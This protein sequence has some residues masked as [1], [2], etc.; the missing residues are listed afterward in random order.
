MT[1]IHTEIT[2]THAQ[3]RFHSNTSSVDG[4]MERGG[5]VFGIRSGASAGSGAGGGC[6]S[7]D[8]GGPDVGAEDDEEADGDGVCSESR[9]DAAFAACLALNASNFALASAMLVLMVEDLAFVLGHVGGALHFHNAILLIE[10]RA[11]G[12][13]DLFAHGKPF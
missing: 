5:G 13:S 6:N 11:S 2:Y 8:V 7:T 10:I 12:G 3:T 9:A 1:C 4:L